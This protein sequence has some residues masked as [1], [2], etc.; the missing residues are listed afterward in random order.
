MV[1]HYVIFIF[2]KDNLNYL[3]TNRL[4]NNL[5]L[6]WQQCQANDF[7]NTS[8]TYDVFNCTFYDCLFTVNV[9]A[10]VFTKI[11]I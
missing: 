7:R 8:F 5:T 11:V 1:N 6:A 2:T 4:R 10:V 3:I 9:Y